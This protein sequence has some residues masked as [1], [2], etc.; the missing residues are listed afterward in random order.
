MSAADA[1]AALE[2]SALRREVGRLVNAGAL[3]QGYRGYL[4]RLIERAGAVP[5]R[6]TSHGDG[7]WVHSCGWSDS[8]EGDMPPSYCRGCTGDERIDWRALYVLPG[9]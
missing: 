7:L 1:V 6:A 4:D 9:Q 5:E 2:A 3:G 8:G